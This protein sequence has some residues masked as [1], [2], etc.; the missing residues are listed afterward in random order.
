MTRKE[1]T[2]HNHS[3]LSGS[4]I[5]LLTDKETTMKKAAICMAVIMAIAVIV[6]PI[7]SAQCPEGK[8]P[9]TM[10][11]PSGKVKTLCIP[12]NAVKGIE[13]AAE[14]SATTVVA[15]ACPEKCLTTKDLAY[16][17]SLGTLECYWDIYKEHQSYLCNVSVDT[18]IWPELQLVLD[19]GGSYTCFSDK[20]D[21]TW[22]TGSKVPSAD[23]ADACFALLE[24]YDDPTPCPCWSESEVAAMSRQRGFTCDERSSSTYPYLQCHDELVGKSFYVSEDQAM[25]VNVAA[26]GEPIGKLTLRETKACYSDLEPF[27]SSDPTGTPGPISELP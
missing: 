19:N 27:I 4:K 21:P 9:V 10:V 18:K 20:I 8:Q 6:A 3:L 16:F 23:E 11:T 25:C 14:N 22:S 12:E 26:K 24:P 13:N 7:A 2:E 15:A 17:E 1:V 5:A